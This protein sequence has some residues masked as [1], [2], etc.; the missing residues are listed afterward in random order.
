MTT[1]DFSTEDDVREVRA[2][3]VRRLERILGISGLET[4]ISPAGDA[5]FIK[6][7]VGKRAPIYENAIRTVQLELESTNQFRGRISLHEN[8][9]SAFPSSIEA[10][11]LL[12]L[13]TR[14]TRKVAQ[15][16]QPQEYTVPYVPFRN[17]EDHKL[18]Q[19]ATHVIVGRRG[20]G[21]STLIARAMELL[22]SGPNIAVVVDM[23]AYS[24]LT[25]DALGR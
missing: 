23:Q 2:D 17:G 8:T 21:K 22:R 16:K 11:C 25:G 15:S 20:V 3:I 1:T 18:A 5:S 10:S 19:P 7:L 9:P 13:L 24:E 12:A 4:T 6:L 14:V